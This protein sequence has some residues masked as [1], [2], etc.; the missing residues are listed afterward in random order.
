MYKDKDKQREAQRER[1]R[2][3]RAKQKALP[4]GVTSEGVTDKALP[5]R[6]GVNLDALNIAAVPNDR[7]GL[8]LVAPIPNRGKPG[9]EDYNGIC[10]SEWIAERTKV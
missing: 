5:K 7:G 3:Y 2:R 8:K 4:K 10:T 6:T 1:T 9:D